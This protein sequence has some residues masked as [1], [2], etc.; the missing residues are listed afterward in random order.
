MLI[1]YL[2][3]IVISRGSSTRFSQIILLEQAV[4]SLFFFILYFHGN[5]N[6]LPYSNTDFTRFIDKT[7]RYLREKHVIILLELLVMSFVLYSHGNKNHLPYSN[8]DFTRF[9]DKTFRY[10]RYLRE[11]QRDHFS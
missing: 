7:F 6:P 8:S 4:M 2:I 9:I 10:F 3:P 1:P 5:K 11:K